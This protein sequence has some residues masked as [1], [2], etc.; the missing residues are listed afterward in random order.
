MQIPAIRMSCVGENRN[1][2]R[3]KNDK[4]DFVDNEEC[5]IDSSH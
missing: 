3:V 2:M 1:L 5:Q 4:D